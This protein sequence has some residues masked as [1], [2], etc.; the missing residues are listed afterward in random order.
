[1]AFGGGGG[2]GGP[3]S[4]APALA[5]AAGSTPAASSPSPS[6][7]VAPGKRRTFR[8]RP[9]LTPPEIEVATAAPE[10]APGYIFYTPG[11]GSGVDGPTI[12]DDTGELV[13]ARA[14]SG[15][16]VADFRVVQYAGRPALA[17]WEGTVNGGIGSGDFVLV[18]ASYHEIARIE[19]G[20]GV[21]ADLHELQITPNGTA[22][23][24]ADGQTPA[25]GSDVEPY[26][27]M[28]CAI[29]EIDLASG[30][31][32]WS[33]HSVDHIGIDESYATPPT[34]GQLV[35]DYAH[36]NSIEVDTDGGLLVSARNTS[37]I[38]KI[39]RATGDIVWRLGGRKSDFTMADGA[40][41]SWQ[42]DARRQPD[43]TLSL[44]DDSATPGRSRALVLALD[45]GART[46]RRVRD[47]VHPKGLLAT[48]QGNAQVLP[49]G[50][51]FVGWGSQP[52]FSEF[53]PDGTL[54]F[55]ATFPAGVQSYR[56][57]RSPWI[58]RPAD[59]PAVAVDESQAG[60]TVHA[61]W[62]GATEVA[63]WSVLG[64]TSAGSLTP[65]ASVPRAGFETAI[66]VADRPT[67]VAVRA[68]AAD[69]T[70]LGTS[71]PVIVPA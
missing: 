25:P 46:A 51:V 17:W 60:L 19:A 66:G 32:I 55:D 61:S 37:A 33:W 24:F 63:R 7:S 40:A 34:N 49:N 23:F 29:Q 48:S 50:D 45:E 39:D 5:L 6:P 2:G 68:L 54:L 56:D 42:H 9:D 15:R 14:G 1:V 58:G 57:T 53:A 38:Y 20:K 21:A 30:R 13:W 70:V 44:F 59:A 67:I 52:F 69:G 26:Q 27:V 41:F 47:F 35:F 4:T 3:G 43:G 12:V 8:T 10:R 65:I 64:G 18:D 16:A 28:D 11:N 36:L 31:L 71:D 22:L 62:N